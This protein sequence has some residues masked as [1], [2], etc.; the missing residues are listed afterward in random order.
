MVRKYHID[1]ITARINSHDISD[2]MT[3][4]IVILIKVSDLISFLDLLTINFYI[5]S[6]IS[7]KTSEYGYEYGNNINI[8]ITINNFCKIRGAAIIAGFCLTV[9]YFIMQVVAGSLS[10]IALSNQFGAIVITTGELVINVI[11]Q[12][13]IGKVYCDIQAT[14]NVCSVFYSFFIFSINF[15]LFVLSI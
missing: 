10:N 13:S 5:I 8:S 11:R 1:R 14:H 7:D 4:V 2:G 6:S 15:C 9:I 12:S 3:V